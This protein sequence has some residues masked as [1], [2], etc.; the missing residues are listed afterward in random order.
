MAANAGKSEA[1]TEHDSGIARVRER[2]II[3]G[4]TLIAIDNIGTIQILDV[5]RN[6][7]MARWG[8][9]AALLGVGAM[10]MPSNPYSSSGSPGTRTCATW[11]GWV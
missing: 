2:T 1:P 3:L 11:G 5:K 4:D 9:F 10:M 7:T 8:I 6:W